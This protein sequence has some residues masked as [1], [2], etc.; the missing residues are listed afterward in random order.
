[1]VP[2]ERLVAGRY[3]LLRTL[4][5]AGVG[6]VWL[7][8]DEMLH[9]LVA[10]KKYAPPA[11]LGAEEQQRVRELTMR[12][13]RAVARAANPN[14]ISILDVLPD[15]DEP[16]IVMEYVASRSLLQVIEETGPLPPARVAAVGLAVLHGLTGTS[17][18]GVRHLDVEPATVLIGDGGR[19]VLSDFG[20][21]DTGVRLGSPRY[22]APERLLG[23]GSTPEAD[24]WS[25]GA[26]LYHAVEGRPPG[27]TPARPVRAGPLT[28]VLEDLLRTDPAARPLPAEVEERLRTVA[29]PPA[30]LPPQPS[31]A[32]APSRSRRVYWAAA[33]AAAAVIAGAGA[34]A[35]VPRQ[36][37]RAPAQPTVAASPTARTAI[38]LPRGFTWWHDP[39][40][41]RVAVPDGWRRGRDAAGVLTFTAPGGSPTLRISRYATPPGDVVAALVAEE[42]NVRLAAYRRIRIEALPEP[43]NAVWEYTY[44]SRSGKEMRGLR[45]L[46]TADGE[47]YAVE[48]QAPRRAWAAELEKLTVVLGTLSP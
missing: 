17:R 8:A 24:L 35:Q 43:G 27:G 31:A 10:I 34:A 20:P 18:T 13:A 4:T 16:W 23:G 25:L 2:Q 9:R 7:A 30:P 5:T 32:P 21:A 33:V 45:R 40:G 3:R 19:I 42:D 12:E 48:W 1:M 44:Q 38:V 36:E 15:E 39:T 26:T 41:F 6:R 46:L 29:K 11:G 37:D 47:A 28:G 22:V 14:V